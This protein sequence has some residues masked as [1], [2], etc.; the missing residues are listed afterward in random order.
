MIVTNLSKWIGDLSSQVYESN[1]EDHLHV[2]RDCRLA[3]STWTYFLPY[4]NK[5]FTVDFFNLDIK[6]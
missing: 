6:S 4:N 2:L 3:V 5:E 1:I